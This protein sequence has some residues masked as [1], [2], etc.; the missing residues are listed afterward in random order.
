MRALRWTDLAVPMLALGLGLGCDLFGTPGTDPDGG[1]VS[2]T[3]RFGDA[4]TVPMDCND[5]LGCIDGTCGFLGTTVEGAACRRSGECIEG[6]YCAPGTRVCEPAGTGED[7][8]DCAFDGDCVAGLVCTI[9]GFGGRC[10]AGGTGDIGTRCTG[11]GDCLAGLSCIGASADNQICTDPLVARDEN[12]DPLLDEDGNPIV[13]PSLPPFWPGETCV[14]EDG[15]PV[16]AYFRVPR[17][18]GADRDFYRLPYPND[19]RRTDGGLDLTGHPSPGTVLPFDIL[20]QYIEASEGDLEGFATNPT[21]YFRFSRPYEFGDINGDTVL[22]YDLETGG[23]L[24][25]SWLV[26]AGPFTR[27]ICP[28]WVGVRTG[29]GAPLRPGRTYAAILTTGIRSTDGETFQRGADLDALLAETAPSDATLAAAYPAYAPLRA[30]LAEGVEGRP[31]SAEVLNAAVFTTQDAQAPIPALREAIRAE[32]APTLSDLTVCADGVASPCDDGEQRTCATD[33]RYWEV[34]G[35]IGL[36]VF[37]EGTAPYELPEDGGGITYDADGVPQ[38]VRTEDVCMVMTIPKVAAVPEEG[39]PVVLYGHGT[40]GASTSPVRNGLA[41]QFASEDGGAGV[42]N[43]VTIGFDLP[44]HGTRRGDSDRDPDGLVFNFLNPRAARDVFLQG[45]ADMM[46][47]VYW[48]ESASVPSTEL[49]GTFDDGAVTFDATRIAVFGHSQG[50]THAALILPHEPSVFAFLLSGA[51]GDLAQ[52]LLTKTQPVDIASAVP[53][54]L[55]DADG[56]GRLVG[57]AFHPTMQLFQQFFERVDP[58]N[59]GLHY[60]REPVEGRPVPHIFMTYGIGDTFSTEETQQALARAARFPQV[61]PELSEVDLGLPTVAPGVQGNVA[62]GG[63][64]EP[65]TIALRQYQQTDPDDDGHFVAFREDA[66][67][68]DVVRFLLQA[69]AGATPQVGD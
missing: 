63:E 5:G 14:E 4:C 7:G 54:A 32:A 62:R 21:V 69:L 59:Y 47:I 43:A 11:Q 52:S 46:A 1:G 40:G 29:P 6:F 18:E 15:E 10:R 22:L 49:P 9:E 3:G 31:T 57:G 34:H 8:A 38:R 53:F 60:F 12:G 25:R 30:F 67:R 17:G 68:A 45:S 50:A 56:D 33:E 44:Q 55:L 35:R 37:Q 2:V 42:A 39:F 66:G 19:V 26:S 36:P 16:E 28:N 20:A 58:V 13:I 27:Y 41:G 51:G 24:G 61:T 65:V 23:L 48:L 64:L